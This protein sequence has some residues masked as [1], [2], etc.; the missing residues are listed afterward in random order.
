LK[1]T[2]EYDNTIIFFAS[3]N[4]YSMAGYM[5]RGNAPHWYDDPWLKNKGPFTGG[6]F[7]VLEGGCRVPFFVSWPAKYKPAIINEP[8]WLPDFFPTA[9]ELAGVNSEQFELDGI[10]LLPALNGNLDQFEGHDFL[11]FSKGR[12]QAV[13]MGPW[14]AYRKN[15]DS[16]T[17]LFL[18]EED[19][20]T[21][22]NLA[23]L[24]PEKVA[25]AE[26]IMKREHEPSEWYWN[27][28]ETSEQYQAKQKLAEETGNI[29]PA[30]RPNGMKKLPWEK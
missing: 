19:T 14:K 24:Y 8:V 9:C 15:P 21:E 28:W 23:S 7:S 12:E 30:F 4:G 25:E 10:N 17:E 29:L 26:E 11:Y 18:V 1:E 6:K 22:R 20:Y 16:K 27:P 13:R 5:N 2:C 3:D